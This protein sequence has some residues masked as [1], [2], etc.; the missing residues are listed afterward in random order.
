MHY[1][2]KWSSEFLHSK[3]RYAL[4]MSK[5]KYYKIKYFPELHKRNQ[6]VGNCRTGVVENNGHF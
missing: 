1:Q 3:L 5:A 2:T 6:E 4:C